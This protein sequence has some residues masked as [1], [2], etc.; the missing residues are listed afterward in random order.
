MWTFNQVGYIPEDCIPPRPACCRVNHRTLDY[1]PRMQ[2]SLHRNCV[3]LPSV[4]LYRSKSQRFPSVIWE[5]DTAASHKWLAM[6]DIARWSAN[7]RAIYHLS[8]NVATSTFEVL[9]LLH[10]GP[11]CGNKVSGPLLLGWRFVFECVWLLHAK[12]QWRMS[13]CRS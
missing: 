1:P 2:P 9:L 4:P 10:P 7:K 5:H 13:Q 3:R 12:L 6:V 8:S 11:I